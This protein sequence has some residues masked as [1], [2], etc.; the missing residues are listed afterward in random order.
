MR[1]FEF[2]TR[3]WI[4][5]RTRRDAAY[6]QTGFDLMNFLLSIESTVPKQF[7]LHQNRSAHTQ[8][9]SKLKVIDPSDIIIIILQP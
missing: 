3:R 8:V 7:V 4:A 2:N 9:N 6:K 1:R 5:Y